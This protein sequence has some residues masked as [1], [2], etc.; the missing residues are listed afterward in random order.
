[1]EEFNVSSSTIYDIK[2]QKEE[3]YKFVCKSLSGSL[4]EWKVMKKPKL[5]ELDEVL[6][7]WFKVRRSEGK[8]VLGPVL[9]EHYWTMCLLGWLA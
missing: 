9:A 4:I 2:K 6:Y 7:K 8:S 1:M 3:L 5:V